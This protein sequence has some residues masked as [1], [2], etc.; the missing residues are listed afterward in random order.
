[1]RLASN[2]NCWLAL[3]TFR[4]ILKKIRSRSTSGNL[5][6]CKTQLK[7]SNK[8]AK[9]GTIRGDRGLIWHRYRL[10]RTVGSCNSLQ[11]D[12]TRALDLFILFRRRSTLY[13]SLIKPTR[14]LIKNVASIS[15]LI[16]E[17][18]NSSRHSTYSQVTSDSVQKT[19]VILITGSLVKDG[20]FLTIIKYFKT[21]HVSPHAFLGDSDFPTT[22]KGV[23]T[24]RAAN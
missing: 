3:C 7:L 16:R 8:W 24:D 11:L 21:C 2:T 23:L 18:T 9:R 19:S 22:D 12:S 17:L 1:M 20:M 14:L 15:R 10:Y 4:G 5:T 6:N 13:W